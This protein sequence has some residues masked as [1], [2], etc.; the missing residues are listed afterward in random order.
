MTDSNEWASYTARLKEELK[1]AQ[2]NAR[3]FKSQYEKYRNQTPDVGSC[4]KLQMGFEDDK[5]RLLKAQI[6]RFEELLKQL[7]AF[8]AKRKK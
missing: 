8:K 5:V 3:F 6:K 4:H 7:P 2:K 1:K